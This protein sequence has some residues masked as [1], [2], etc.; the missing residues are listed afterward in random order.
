MFL[1]VMDV[2]EFTYMGA[3]FTFVPRKL[4]KSFKVSKNIGQGKE[5]VLPQAP[6]PRVVTPESHVAHVDVSPQDDKGKAKAVEKST[7]KHA[8]SDEDYAM[9]VSLSLSDYSL[10]SDSD[11]RRTLHWNSQPDAD[12]EGC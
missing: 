2:I 8:F 7:G 12:N 6:S 10:W 9:L 5:A 11:L 1:M 3:P 4:I